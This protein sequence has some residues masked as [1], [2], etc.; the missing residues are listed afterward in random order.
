MPGATS[1]GLAPGTQ[2]PVLRGLD[3]FRV[4]VQENGV[5]SLDVSDYGEQAGFEAGA[6]RP[7]RLYLQ[8]ASHMLMPLA[9]SKGL[10]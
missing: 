8:H 2:R 4:R 6:D 5:G 7:A 10:P 1:A 3:D 9:A